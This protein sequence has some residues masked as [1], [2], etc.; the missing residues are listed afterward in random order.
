M[1]YDDGA[2]WAS[3]GNVQ[4]APGQNAVT[5]TIC[6][7]RDADDN[8]KCDK[9]EADYTDGRDL[10][11]TV[12]VTF[13]SDGGTAVESQTVRFGSNVKAPTAPTKDGYTFLGWYV[14]DEEWSF[15]GY[16]VSED[17]TLTAKWELNVYTVVIVYGYTDY[18]GYPITDT[19][20]VKH[21]KTVPNCGT[22]SRNYYNFA[23]WTCNGET[24]SF[25][26]DTVTGDITITA[27]WEA[28]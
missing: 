14:G 10:E 9:C 24:W 25:D 7:H 4:G 20:N 19:Y 13:D 15:I 8:N 23:G 1:S 26:T 18:W 3:L 6:Q 22:P 2:S 17:I 21:G 5:P 28:I 16:S 12:V 27:E 11:D